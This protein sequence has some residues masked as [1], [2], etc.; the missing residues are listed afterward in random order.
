MRALSE[1]QD[2]FSFGSQFD[3][4]HFPVLVHKKTSPERFLILFLIENKTKQQDTHASL[5]FVLSNMAL[6]GGSSLQFDDE[7]TSELVAEI[8]ELDRK[9]LELGQ[10]IGQVTVI[11]TVYFGLLQ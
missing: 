3:D 2:T 8:Y 1:D 11:P 4:H 5:N 10:L 7:G 6:N 9:K